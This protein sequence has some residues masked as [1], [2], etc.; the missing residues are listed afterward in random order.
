MISGFSYKTLREEVVI[1]LRKRILSGE[2]KPGERIKE[3]EI[4]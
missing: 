3:L 1:I 4:S 2:I